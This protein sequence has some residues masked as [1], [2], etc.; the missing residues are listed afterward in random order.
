VTLSTGSPT[1]VPL[2]ATEIHVWRAELD[3]GGWPA[4][5]CLPAAERERAGRLL[6]PLLRRR[7]VASRWALRSVL[8]HYLELDPA[9]VELRV[10]SRGKPMLADPATPLRFNLSHSAARALVAV[11]WGREVGVDLEWIEPDRH[12]PA[13]YA[14]WTRREAIAKCHGTGLGAPLP[15][16][17]ETDV[18]DLDLGPGFAAALAVSGRP[19]PAR[20]LPTAGARVGRSRHLECAAA[21]S[22]RLARLR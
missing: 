18:C 12:P 8:G 4:A 16:G 14:A 10:A 20:P 21:S 11:A 5:E 2:P 22:S 15:A 3:H 17:A 1:A 7:W 13:F 19:T 9:A 6:R